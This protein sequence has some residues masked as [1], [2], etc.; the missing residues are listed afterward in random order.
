V[1]NEVDAASRCGWRESTERS[2]PRAAR[3]SF[4]ALACVAC[5]SCVIGPF[6][7]RDAGITT[8][9]PS[10]D[11]VDA[12]S[13]DTVA[14]ADA[15][16]VDAFD[17]FVLECGPDG[18]TVC[19]CGQTYCTSGCVSILGDTSNCGGCAIRCAR[20]H[21]RAACVEGNCVYVCAPGYALQAGACVSQGAP[22]LVAPLSTS[23]TTS[24]TPTLHWVP[25]RPGAS[26]H[27]QVC[28]TRACDSIEQQFDATGT[29][30]PVPMPLSRGVHFWRAFD[31]TGSTPGTAPSATWQFDVRGRSASHDGWWG[32]RP[33]FDGDGHTDLA[34]GVTD[35]NMGETGHAVL[36]HGTTN[37]VAADTPW[38]VYYSDPGGGWFGDD[39]HSV[40]D[41]DGDGY[42]EL[43]IGALYS[44]HST[45]AYLYYGGPSFPGDHPEFGPGA[46]P[47]L[48]LLG[49]YGDGF[50]GS[51]VSAGD[52]NGDGYGD[53]VITLGT[54]GGA[55]VYMGSEAGLVTTGPVVIS[56]PVATART[57]GDFNA[58]GYGDLVL[59]S[60]WNG[61]T[62][63]RVEVWYGSPSGIIPAPS[64]TFQ[65]DP[66]GHPN[67][68]YHPNSMGDYNGDGYAD[69]VMTYVDGAPMTMTGASFVYPGG[70]MGLGA[71]P[72]PA[73]TLPSPVG[74]MDYYGE[75]PGDAGDLN[76][77]GF[78]DLMV[79]A[80]QTAMNTGAVYIYP[81]SATGLNATGRGVIM[82]PDGPGGYFGNALSWAGDVNGDGY[83]DAFVAAAGYVNTGRVYLV[84]IGPGFTINGQV[85]FDD[86]VATG[87]LQFGFAVASREV[88]NDPLFTLLG[89]PRLPIDLVP[90][91]HASRL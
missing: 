3:V 63:G 39:I 87:Y 59:S 35:P 67:A 53:V 77:D 66:M 44:D 11:A 91:L 85:D 50:G 43:G 33:D 27:V 24:Q 69:L 40:G 7:A 38:C 74:M 36:Y 61:S 13:V 68:Y 15:G 57:T 14:D 34:I 78:D 76:R 16:T 2:R 55:R 71:S 46:H 18:S 60:S 72:T 5:A 26:V 28:A 62:P 29:S 73:L 4:A 12:T 65:P 19:P 54:I 23:R 41:V 80:K 88:R 47:D 84:F 49:H 6:R 86:P 31:L 48:R 1:A 89:T 20:D 58:D 83:D 30:A 45:K 37:S 25:A 22:R 70:P 82:G 64:V 51:V 81:G 56:P 75:D 52:L 10:S 8:D 32:T 17:G 79:G 90:A 21:A 9:V 42:P